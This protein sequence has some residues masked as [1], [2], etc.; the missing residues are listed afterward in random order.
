MSTLP[1]DKSE[2]TLEDQKARCVNPAQDPSTRVIGSNGTD[3]R[4]TCRPGFRFESGDLRR[5]CD[6]NGTWSGLQPV[7]TVDS[8]MPKAY[9]VMLIVG[10]IVTVFLACIPYDFY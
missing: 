4:Y 8:I 1:T 6:V 5:L 7:C 10:A 2:M 3:I 9:L